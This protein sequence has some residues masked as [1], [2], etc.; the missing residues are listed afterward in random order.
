MKFELYFLLIKRKM[1]KNLIKKV[2]KRTGELENFDISKISNAI[3]K[4]MKYVREKD[5]KEAKKLA[6]EVVIELNKRIN[7]FKEGIPN[8]EQIQDVVEEIFSR[9]KFERAAKAYMLYRRGRTHARE[10]KAFFGIKDDLKFDVNAIRVLQER[11]LLRDEKGRIIETPTEMFERVARAIA[12][13]EKTNKEKWEKRFFP[14][15]LSTSIF[16]AIP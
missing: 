12:S 10:L 16:P 3:E 13:V 9:S 6:N 7:E 4:A 15:H 1:A 14:S 11:Y 5:G 8:V 2:R